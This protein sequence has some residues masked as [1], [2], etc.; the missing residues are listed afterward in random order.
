MNL[1]S[2]TVDRTGSSTNVSTLS[3]AANSLSLTNNETIGL[4]GNG[5]V[6]QSGGT[7]SIGGTLYLGHNSESSGS[8]TLSAGTL[9]VTGTTF[10]GF[11]PGVGSLT[12]S[13]DG[14]LNANG[15][16]FDEGPLTLSGGTI[17][18]SGLGI[19]SPSQFHWTAG[20]INLNNDA[21]ID[22]NTSPGWGSSLSI[23]AGQALTV[24]NETIGATGSGTLIQTAGTN[25]VRSNFAV[26]TNDANVGENI[27]L[28]GTYSLSGTGSLT[29]TTENIGGDGIGT[30]TQNG[31]SNDCIYELFLGFDNA[32]G[33][34]PTGTYNLESGSL[35]VA[36]DEIVGVMGDGN[37]N[38][39]GGTQTIGS[40]LYIAQEN[41]STASYLVQG[42]SLQVAGPCTSETPQAFPEVRAVS[43]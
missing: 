2:L 29:A 37:F 31:G 3:I 19:Y 36:V 38:Q 34:M 11:S 21:I 24:N 20:A 35:S 25:T 14:T 33:V 10:V 32:S 17:N 1:N 43:L 12:V 9:T 30:V 23:G 27:G 5:A 22:S 40:N 15:G 28:S 42:G 39:T 4:N 16:L 18:A 6:A 7:V 8:Y 26:G 41:G 13:G